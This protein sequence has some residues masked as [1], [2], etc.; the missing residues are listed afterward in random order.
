MTTNYIKL[1]RRGAA[2]WAILFLGEEVGTASRDTSKEAQLGLMQIQVVMDY[3]K[4]RE[5]TRHA[6]RLSN[7]PQIM[8]PV[9]SDNVLTAVQ[10]GES[11]FK[12]PEIERS[13][14]EAVKHVASNGF[15][16]LNLYIR[17]EPGR[18]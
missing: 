1:E 5:I 9:M 6:L 11:F 2:K 16:G 18:R 14:R 3:E 4:L 8:V 13:I 12:V 15:D 7:T 10:D 17:E